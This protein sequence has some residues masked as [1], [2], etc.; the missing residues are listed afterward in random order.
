MTLAQLLQLRINQ[1]RQ[2][3]ANRDADRL[4]KM[5]LNVSLP[6]AI[7]VVQEAREQAQKAVSR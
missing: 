5:L 7:K 6:F 3:Q 4:V 1:A 2:V